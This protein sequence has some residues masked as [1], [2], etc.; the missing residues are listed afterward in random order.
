MTRPHARRDT[1]AK[2]AANNVICTTAQTR[3][4]DAN[5][6]DQTAAYGQLLVRA[7]GEAGMLVSEVQSTS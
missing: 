6:L 7:V 3:I 5:A 2:V 4:V 1:D